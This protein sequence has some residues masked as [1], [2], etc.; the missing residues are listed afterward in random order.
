MSHGTK[1]PYATCS[2][3][4]VKDWCGRKNGKVP[5][6]TDYSVNPECSGYIL[7]EQ[8]FKLSNIP[9]E[10]SKAI[11]ENFKFDNDNI[12]YREHFN[13]I[14]N[15]ITEQVDR[16]N[17]I[18]LIHPQKGTG[19]TYTAITFAMEYLIN[20]TLKPDRFD[21]EK[22]LILYVKY[23]AWANELR[24]VYQLNDEDYSS[25]VLRNME[26]MQSVPL[27]ILDDIGSGRLTNYVRDLTYNL[28]DYRKENKL[29]TF[30]TSNF[31]ISQLEKADCLG[32]IIISRLLYNTTIFQLGGHDRRRNKTLIL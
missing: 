20:N 15:T 17:N 16:G 13:D 30:F 7:L 3:C 12:K 29:S 19:K 14:L 22:P 25:K 24:Q 11:R 28:I 23:G 4:I 6:P 27:L 32:D 31:G 10:Y 9:T 8:A 26:R 21:F 1:E 5:L 18:G 2:G